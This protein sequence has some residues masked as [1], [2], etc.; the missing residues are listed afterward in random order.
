MF[1]RIKDGLIYDYAD[2]E[3]A[4]DCLYSAVCTMKEYQQNPDIYEL[5]NDMLD[6]VEN[7]QEVISTQRR[8]S[9][10]KE[11]FVTSL[12]WIRRQVNMMDGSKKD[13]LADLLLSVKA[14]MEMGQN[15]KI[16]TYKTPDFSKEP[17]TEYIESLQEIKSVTPE[18]IQECLFQTVKD[19]G[20]FDIEDDAADNSAV[21]SDSPQEEE[22]ES[23]EG[24]NDGI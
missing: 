24:G 7:Y 3:Y 12:G 18:F 19:F 5:H 21:S 16:I 17:T 15:V 4:H 14:G 11:F 20:A 8:E 13:F 22:T 10:E 6:F 9:F 1:Y 23:L 2:Y